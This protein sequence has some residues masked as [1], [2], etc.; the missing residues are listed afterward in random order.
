MEKQSHEDGSIVDILGLICLPSYRGRTG[1]SGRPRNFSQCSVLL[2][3]RRAVWQILFNCTRSGGGDT[4]GFSLCRGHTAVWYIAAACRHIYLCTQRRRPI[5]K[6]L[7]EF[8]CECV[9]VG[10]ANRASSVWLLSL[11]FQ[12]SVYWGALSSRCLPRVSV[13][14]T[15]LV[16]S[17]DLSNYTRQS[18]ICVCKR[19]T[20]LSSS[21]LENA[22]SYGRAC[23][24]LLLET[25]AVPLFK[26]YKPIADSFPLQC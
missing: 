2:V 18:R 20:E 25:S 1:P 9:A 24:A 26:S 11:L 22:C 17:S 14:L 10:K 21:P 23:T 6:G 16:E 5:A 8:I 13:S 4:Q 12:R 3:I 7:R 19:A 15:N